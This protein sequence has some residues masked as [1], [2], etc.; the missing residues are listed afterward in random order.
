[1][2]RYRHEYK[3]IISEQQKNILM[4]KA[5]GLMRKDSYVNEK[6]SYLI[7][8]LYFDDWNNS[9]YYENE[10]GTDPRSKFRIR[11]YNGDASKIKL[12]KKIKNRGMTLKQTCAISKE[13]CEVFMSGKVPQSENEIQKILFEEMKERKMQPKVIV[14]YERIPYIY[15]IGNVRV[16]FDM[17]ITSSNEITKFLQANFLERPILP[18][19]KSVLEVKWDEVFPAHIKEYMSLDDLQW[20]TFSKYYLC[21]K[22]NINGGIR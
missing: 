2:S 5:S 11:Y 19:G 22:Y 14:S 20:S 7:R 17:N 8:S 10:D 13:Q 12:E 6:G 1:M 3:Y 4:I 21:R 18:L 9:C 16:T 15:G